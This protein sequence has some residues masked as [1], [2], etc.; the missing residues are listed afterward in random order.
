MVFASITFLFCLFPLFMLGD[1]AGRL[2][3]SLQW[4][5]GVMLGLSLLFYT[6]GE[7]GNVLLL[8]AMG[9]FNHL[10]GQRLGARPSRSVLAAGIF[11][12]MGV[13]VGY[14]YA[15][16][17]VG[18]LLP[19]TTLPVVGMPLGISFFTFHAVSYLVDVYCRR[20]GPAKS[21]QDF[22][23]YFCMFPHLVAG[24]IV[25]FAQVSE[26]L[27]SRRQ[28]SGLFSFGVYRLLLGLNKKVLIADSVA[29]LAD[30]AFQLSAG[31]SLGMAD[32]W[33]GILAYAMQIYFDFSGYSD[34]AIGLAAMAG[35]HFEE[36]FKRPYSSTSIRDFWRRWHISLSTW[37]R[38]Y[39]YIPLGGNA[40][41]A[42]GTYRNL[43]LVFFLCGLWHGAN[44]TFVIWGLW[45]GLFLI[46]ERVAAGR[47]H[48]AVPNLAKRAYA[49][50]VVLTG[51]V[52]FRADSVAQAVAYL[53]SMFR[54]DGSPLLVGY[55]GTALAVLVVACVLCAVPDRLLPRPCSR[56]PLGFS[57]W[58][59]AV[60]ACLALFSIAM[61]LRN[62]RN[63]FIYFNF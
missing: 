1:G 62:L 59:Y 45:N 53:G 51:W 21:M 26:D 16:W 55:H 31:G 32:A 7:G 17:L 48:W 34:M 49:L 22:L 46:L 57:L 52:F 12:N 5:N 47:C 25:R 42:F 54:L 38:D 61:L 37:F 33:V 27:V 6:W 50:V 19:N 14:K 11:C 63:P 29:P 43:L 24:P 15:M 44:A 4:R 36:N 3:G 41:G 28:E 39:L 23:V 30:A 40:Y 20:I 10:V 35:F 13:L 60:Q 58:H 8:I 2:V 9:V 56:S 18:L